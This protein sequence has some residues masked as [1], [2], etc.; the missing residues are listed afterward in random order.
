[1]SL[2]FK[3]GFFGYNCEEVVEYI[4][5]LTAENNQTVSTLKEKIAAEAENTAKANQ[6]IEQLEVKIGDAQRELEFYKSKY[7]EVKKLSDNIGKLYLVAQTN[8]KAIMESANEAHD[9]SKS[10]IEK[11]IQI[12]NSTEVSLNSLKEKVSELNRE[13]E[14]YVS[15]ITDD[16]NAIK[17][18]A[19]V[20]DDLSEKSNDDFK[21]AYSSIV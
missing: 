2:G 20:S 13:F 15:S 12:L 16:L 21:K 14:N 10:E 9:A 8:A 1:M 18:L 5:K 4:T 19:S 3:K 17:E 7:E 6:E 11:N